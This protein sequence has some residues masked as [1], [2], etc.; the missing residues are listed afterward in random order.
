M[1][2]IL[3]LLCTWILTIRKI[4]VYAHVFLV[5]WIYLFLFPCFSIRWGK[6][7]GKEQINIHG[8]IPVQFISVLGFLFDCKAQNKE[9]KIFSSTKILL[10]DKIWNRTQAARTKR[11]TKSSKQ[12]EWE[13]KGTIFLMYDTF[14]V[15]KNN[16][17]SCKR[18]FPNFWVVSVFFFFNGINI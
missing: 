3:S 11:T 6:F 18:L 17:V 7:K 8:F 4:L 15:F 12:V 9:I 2:L 5:C 13:E 16:T 14:T 10:N 1:L